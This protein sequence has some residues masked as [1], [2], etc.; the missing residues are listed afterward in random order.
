MWQSVLYMFG[1]C[2][3]HWVRSPFITQTTQLTEV[4]GRW[5][6]Y[7]KK[8]H[9]LVLINEFNINHA[10]P[11][12]SLHEST[13]KCKRGDAS[14]HSSFFSGTF[15]VLPP[16]LS[17]CYWS[18]CRRHRMFILG[19]ENFVIAWLGLMIIEQTHQLFQRI[20]QIWSKS[21]VSSNLKSI[22]IS[23]QSKRRCLLFVLI[24][25]QT[26]PHLFSAHAAACSYYCSQP[27]LS[28]S[29]RSS[30]SP[31][32]LLSSPLFPRPLFLS[33]LLQSGSLQA[34]RAVAYWSSDLAEACKALSQLASNL[35]K[36]AAANS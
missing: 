18:I 31:L 8:K 26:N 1:K 25:V 4:G 34:G 7:L 10:T 11:N 16:C 9:K 6:S 29:H 28:R 22:S 15:L 30:P 5:I 35:P 24:H 13:L 2:T 20:H 32:F 14:K 36:P 17:V 27:K 21:C 23:F 19:K 3:V 33:Y 12:F